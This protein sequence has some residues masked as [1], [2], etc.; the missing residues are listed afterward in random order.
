MPQT[1]ADSSA[2]VATAAMKD[3]GGSR[4]DE[5]GVEEKREWATGRWGEVEE[6]QGEL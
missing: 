3:G 1:E 4:V 5:F 2:T 6:D